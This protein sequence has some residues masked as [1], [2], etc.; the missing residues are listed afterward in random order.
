MCEFEE[1]ERPIVL[2]LFGGEPATVLAR[3]KYLLER[4]PSCPQCK[5]KRC[6]RAAQLGMTV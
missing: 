6:R 5:H 4:D 3:L 1:I 2:Q